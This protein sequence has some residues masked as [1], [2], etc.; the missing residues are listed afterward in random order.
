ML[1]VNIAK[2]GF[3]YED[4]STAH[5]MMKG[6]DFYITF[7]LKSAYHHIQISE[8]QIGFLGFEWEGSYYVFNVL[9]FSPPSTSS[10]CGTLALSNFPQ[11]GEKETAGHCCY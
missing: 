11:G 3:R 6:N 7:D 9:P 10:L 8:D 5:K 4:V 2:F 1:L